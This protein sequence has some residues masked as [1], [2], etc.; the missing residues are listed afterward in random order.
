MAAVEELFSVEPLA[1]RSHNSSS[2]SSAH[3]AQSRRSR[4]RSLT[5]G[6]RSSTRSESGGRLASSGAN[7]SNPTGQA[8]PVNMVKPSEIE[9]DQIVHSLKLSPVWKILASQAGKLK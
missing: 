8:A 9:L 4:S 1:P 3:G 2:T 7:V 5:E 6:L